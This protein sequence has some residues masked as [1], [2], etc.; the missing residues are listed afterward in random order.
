MDDV[1]AG[2]L[3]QLNLV[4]GSVRVGQHKARP[5]DVEG[6]VDV[7]RVRVLEADS[8]HAD[9]PRREVPPHP[10]YTHEVCH[11]QVH[12]NKPIG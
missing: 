10:F 6:G 2:L 7:H 12:K 3:E 8:M 1:P 11:L 5:D 4:T 9:T